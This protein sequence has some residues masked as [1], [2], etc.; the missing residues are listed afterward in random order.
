MN[1]AHFFGTFT[2]YLLQ[3]RVFEKMKMQYRVQE[4]IQEE[5]SF[6]IF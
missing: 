5:P 1:N 4:A 2:K 6:E 3:E